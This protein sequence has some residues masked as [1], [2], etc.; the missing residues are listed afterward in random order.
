MVPGDGRCSLARLSGD[1]P[2]IPGRPP[3]RRARPPDRLL[4]PGRAGPLPAE[5]HQPGHGAG[6]R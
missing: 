4:P 3:A 2:T 6:H 1:P 5:R